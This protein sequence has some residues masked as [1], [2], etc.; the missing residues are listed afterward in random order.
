[1]DRYGVHIL[2]GKIRTKVSAR[3]VKIMDIGRDEHIFMDFDGFSI[4]SSDFP[5]FVVVFDCIVLET[6]KEL[7]NKLGC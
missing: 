5:D 7:H 4:K 1:M 6:Q 3:L 2:Y